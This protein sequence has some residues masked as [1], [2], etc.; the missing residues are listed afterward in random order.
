LPPPKWAGKKRGFCRLPGAI[1]DARKCE[2]A[3][4][5]A[6]AAGRLGRDG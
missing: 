6:P 3:L 1:L 4:E 5:L 2:Q